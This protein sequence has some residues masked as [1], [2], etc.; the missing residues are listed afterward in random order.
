ML[1]L[2]ID[3]WHNIALDILLI[4]MLSYIFYLANSLLTIDLRIFDFPTN[5]CAPMLYRMRVL[6]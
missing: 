1:F 6:T 2:V 3:F 5:I 4:I